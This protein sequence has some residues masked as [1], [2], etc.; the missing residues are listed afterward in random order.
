MS[1]FEL[2]RKISSGA[3]DP[4]STNSS[5]NETGGVE[6][7]T[8]VRQALYCLAMGFSGFSPEPS[9]PLRWFH[10]HEIFIAAAPSGAV[11][12]VTWLEK[13]LVG[14]AA[15]ETGVF[16][17]AGARSRAF[18]FDSDQ[19]RLLA[20]DTVL[21]G[22][23]ESVADGGFGRAVGHQHDRDD[24]GRGGFFRGAL[25]HDRLER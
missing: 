25:L 4:Q 22:V 5:R 16:G 8:F 24:A 10:P 3:S 21:H 2:G 6:S 9:Q 17:F 18:P 13:D 11:T 1:K 15:Q 23:I 14:A 20:H 7:R 19:L 12:F